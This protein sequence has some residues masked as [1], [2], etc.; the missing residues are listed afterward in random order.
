MKKVSKRK[1]LVMILVGLFLTILFIGAFSGGGDSPQ[2][3]AQSVET[4]ASESITYKQDV[5]SQLG[6]TSETLKTYGVR[7]TEVSTDPL[8]SQSIEFS[9]FLDD[10]TSEIRSIVEYIEGMDVPAAYRE[11]HVQLIEGYNE[12][13]YA[14]VYIQSAV[15]ENN[16]EAISK[17]AEKLEAA[18]EKILSIV[19]EF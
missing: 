4:V 6:R 19:S 1:M 7:F 3:T 9:D 17:G 5:A 14:F 15:H 12:L 13:L 10:S 18:N 11:A 2:Q 8:L 16:V